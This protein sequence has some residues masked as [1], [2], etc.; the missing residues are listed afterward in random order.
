MLIGASAWSAQLLVD[1]VLVGLRCASGADVYSWAVS[2]FSL[3]MAVLTLV[4]LVTSYRAWKRTQLG[5]DAEDRVH[6]S[7]GRATMMA[8]AGLLS[9][10]VFLVL[11]VESA[12]PNTFMDPCV[13]VG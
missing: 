10:I 9:N 1:Y 7:L 2:V 12:V 8:L 6:P 11:I 13:R 4:G 5:L 3:L